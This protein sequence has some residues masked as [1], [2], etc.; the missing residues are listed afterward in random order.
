MACSSS[1]PRYDQLSATARGPGSHSTVRALSVKLIGAKETPSDFTFAI[2]PS[3]SIIY[4][5]GPYLG[6]G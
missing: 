3:A 2:A 6:V 4:L 5:C 1:Q